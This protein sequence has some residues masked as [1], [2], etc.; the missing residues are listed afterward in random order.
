MQWQRD[1]FSRTA[2][3]NDMNPGLE[4]PKPEIVVYMVQ[5]S[6]PKDIIREVLLGIEEEGLPYKQETTKNQITAEDLAY[7][8]A[9]S[10]HL[11]VGIGIDQHQIVLHYIKLRGGKPLFSISTNEDE[12]HL[13]AIGANAARVVKH[14]PFKMLEA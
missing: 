3:V 2:K 12:E 13:R 7:K 10:S 9:E 4:A 1:S 14:M 11:G 5:N 6:V 8:A